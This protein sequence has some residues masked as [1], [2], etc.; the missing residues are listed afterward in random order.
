MTRSTIGI[1]FATAMLAAACIVTACAQGTDA[2]G[3]AGSTA[4][5]GAAGA[6]GAGGSNPQGGNAGNPQGGNA[7]NPQGGNAGN[8]QGGSSGS[9][10]GGSAGSAEGGSSGSGHAGEGGGG[11][12]CTAL[13]AWATVQDVAMGTSATG[14]HVWIDGAVAESPMVLTYKSGGGNCLWAVFV[15]D[16]SQPYATMV[17]S[18]GD[19]APAADGGFGDCPATG[20][21]FPDNVAPGDKLV[22]TGD[23]SPYAPSGCTAT[24]QVQ[25][26]AC[27]V[28]RTSTGSAPTA[29]TV[30][31][32][33]IV[34][35]AAQ[36]QGLL[37]KV[38]NVD[39]EMWPDAGTIGP[40]G[41]IKLTGSGLEVHDKFY[42]R[43]DG[44]P[45]FGD[46]Q[47][48]ASITGIVHLD[49]CTWVLQPV[50]KCKDFSP[51]S[52]DCP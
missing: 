51:K 22:I 20:T 40:Y 39:A 14:S 25:V 48:F 8:P 50:D 38:E 47:H 43:E 26:N 21:I 31:P 6:A 30:Q 34:S 27:S 32:A 42:Y 28:T 44:A 4:K 19:P 36:Y 16:P 1:G 24:K 5:G 13:G 15:R 52:T 29:V 35:G 10:E 49:Y 23:V 7:G 45:M 17:I 12:K 2:D 18:Y 3:G 9:G 41:S 11:G 46:N 37:V 33:D